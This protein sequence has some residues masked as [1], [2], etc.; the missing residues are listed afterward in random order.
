MQI[1]GVTGDG[2]DVQYGI[3]SVYSDSAETLII[4]NEDAGFMP[5]YFNFDSAD[6]QSV[7]SRIAR[8]CPDVPVTVH[9]YSLRIP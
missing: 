1:T 7:A 9:G 3:E 4:R 8:E 2:R 5:P 6:L